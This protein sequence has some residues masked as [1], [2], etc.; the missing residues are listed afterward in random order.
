MDEETMM[1]LNNY[2]QQEVEHMEKQIS[3]AYHD[4]DKYLQR[5]DATNKIILKL[6]AKIADPEGMITIPKSEYERLLN[7]EAIYQQNDGGLR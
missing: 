3:D 7:C 1:N 4:R 6:Q 2:W 5:L